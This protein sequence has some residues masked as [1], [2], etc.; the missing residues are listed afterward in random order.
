[1]GKLEGEMKVLAK[2]SGGSHKT[3]NDRIHI[4]QRF[5]QH[6]RTL[7]IQIQRVDQIKVRHI[8]SYIQARLA[9]EIGKR[10]L[11]NEMAALRSVLQQTGRKQVAEH[12]RL[13]N[14]ALGLAGAS[15][16]GTKQAI[17]SEH[18]QSVLLAAR[19][20]DPGL[21]AALELA[22]LMGLRSQEA[23]QCSQSLKTWQQALKRGDRQLHIVFGTK[24]GRPRDTVVLDADAVKLAIDKALS[25]SEQ[26][27]G[28]LI[29]AQDLKTAMSYWR[30]QAEWFGLTGIHSPH[31]L[32]YAWAQDAIQHY[33]AHGF[34]EKETLA[35]VAMDLGHGDGRGRYVGR[36]YGVREEG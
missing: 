33:Q 18:Y 26:R 12:E 8:E 13:T 35:L 28:K 25:V 14:K 5:A 31:S 22:R 2:K 11:H 10:T 4:V 3:V 29:N 34:S 23:V 9:Q 32:R 1:M 20:K 7:N 30:K 21:A 27:N 36:V 17:T 6:L 15:R 19:A 24:G 16:A